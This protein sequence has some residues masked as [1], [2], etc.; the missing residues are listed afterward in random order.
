M[1]YSVGGDSREDPGHCRHCVYPLA[2]ESPGVQQEVRDKVAGVRG[3]R[4]SGVLIWNLDLVVISCCMLTSL[5]CPQQTNRF[6]E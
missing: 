5:T 3:A 6:V 4:A 1:S 2:R